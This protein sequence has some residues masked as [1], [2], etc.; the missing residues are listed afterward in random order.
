[1]TDLPKA[2]MPKNMDLP[3]RR[4]FALKTTL[5]PKADLE[6]LSWLMVDKLDSLIQQSLDNGQN[7][8]DLIE[9]T[10]PDLG[11]AIRMEAA[12]TARDMAKAMVYR[13][14]RLNNLLARLDATGSNSP[15]KAAGKVL[16]EQT[17]ESFLEDLNDAL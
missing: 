6:T 1:M 3:E 8:Q 10:Y 9:S 14:D 16:K 11:S 17:L 12:R 4:A 2:W 5:R 13:A 7:P 15:T